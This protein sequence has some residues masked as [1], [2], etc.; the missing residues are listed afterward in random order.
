VSLFQRA[1]NAQA[2]A[3]I[4]ILGFTGDGKTHTACVI[5]IGLVQLLR[6]RNIAAGSRPVLFID[7]E[8]GSDWMKPLFDDAG[9]E[10]WVSRTRSFVDLLTA[11]E[12]AVKAGAVL[13]IDS[14]T[15]FWRVLCDE[16]ML[17]RNRRNGLEISDWSWLKAKWGEFTRAFLNAECHIIICGRAGYIYDRSEDADGRQQVRKTGVQ[18]KAEGETG[19][20]PSLLVLMERQEGPPEEWGGKPRIWRTATILKD[21]S[22]Q[23]DGKTFDDPG[24]DAFRAHIECLNLGGTD[25]GIDF[26]RNN[27]ALFSEDGTPTW[28]RE[29]Q[30][31]D[32]ALDEIDACLAKHFPGQGAEAKAKR[33]EFLEKALDTRS[34]ERAK[35]LPWLDIERGRNFLWITLEGKP[36]SV[37]PVVHQTNEEF[38]DVPM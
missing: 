23:I 20:E 9:I 15:H 33:M 31:K 21:R 3:K 16:Y 5:A 6:E 14:I 34:W 25:E 18:L 32:V 36:Y 1:E 35:T 27:S 7:T 30:W 37:A 4:G 8:R 24:F 2:Y 19:H 26:S 10:L 28:Q 13:I 29:R 12:E 38:G 11:I 22:R 17:R